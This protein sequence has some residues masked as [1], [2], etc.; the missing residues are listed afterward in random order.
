M[1]A[2]TTSKR[3]SWGLGVGLCALYLSQGVVAGVGQM[4]VQIEAQ[5]GAP[6]EAQTGLLAW[7]G[8]P[9]LLKLLWGLVWDR[10]VR[11]EPQARRRRTAALVALQLGAGGCLAA[12]GA[13]GP[14]PWLPALFFSLNLVVSL[15]D[16]GTDALVV[17]GVAPT[18]RSLINGAMLSAR[19]LGVGLLGGSWF[20]AV[21]ID[22]GQGGAL[23]RYGTAIAALA[24]LVALTRQATVSAPQAS[25]PWP[26]LT[27]LI[28]TSGRRYALA[29]AGLTLLGDGLSGA[30]AADFLQ[31]RGGWNLTELASELVPLQVFAEVLAFAA[32][33]VLVGRV[34]AR[35]AVIVGSTALGVAWL[36]FA[37]SEGLWAS[38]D[39]VKGLAVWE[40]SARALL[41]VGV[42]TLLMN[43]TE[44]ERRA[45]HFVVYMTLLNLPRVLD[46]TVAPMLF[47]KVGYAG[48]WALSGLLCLGVTALSF[49]WKEADQGEQSV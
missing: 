47:D 14:S 17:D 29:L 39:L 19:A 34:G 38:H 49:A 2:P 20:V 5:R 23:L 1:S 4:L 10:Y 32:A 22:V 48:I 35:R 6:L 31:K 27:T 46:A 9:W 16:V 13:L 24:I 26:S 28:A 30:V 33:S 11:V 7:G 44:P 25:A 45:T 12:F 43:H 18:D 42:Y 41:L 8:L 21:Y 40:A 3:L 15:Q 36:A 37:F